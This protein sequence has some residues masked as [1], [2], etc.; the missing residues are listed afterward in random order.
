MQRLEAADHFASL[1]Y[2]DMPFPLAP[3]TW[4]GLVARHRRR[5]ARTL[6]GHGDGLDNDLDTA[7]RS[8]KCSG[9]CTAA[10]LPPI[11]GLCAHQ[12][13]AAT[14]AAFGR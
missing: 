10:R 8:R 2:A 3:N 4:A 12:P 1:R 13:D 11:A 7:R 6:R 9:A 5:L 14:L